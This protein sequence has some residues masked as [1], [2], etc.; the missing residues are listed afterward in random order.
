MVNFFTGWIEFIAS[1]VHDNYGL[2]IILVTVCVRVILLPLFVKQQ[3]H[4]TGL[5]DRMKA[6]KPEIDDIRQRMVGAGTQEKKMEAQQ[7]LFHLYKKHKL[8]PI[9]PGLL[10]MLLQIPIFYGLYMAI[11][12][13]NE[14]ADHTFLWFDLGQR[15]PSLA[16]IVGVITFIQMMVVQRYQPPSDN[17]MAEMINR[18]TKIMMPGSL[19]I[20]SLM[21]PA[22]LSLYFAIGGI[23]VI[24]QTILIKNIMKA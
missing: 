24:G 17:Q 12:S 4:M 22:A 7:E 21:V 16:L 14:I 2:A 18:M 9:S 15:D 11:K 1:H 5:Q 23:F 20:V 19:L 8:N 3:K 10:P 13:S 6:V